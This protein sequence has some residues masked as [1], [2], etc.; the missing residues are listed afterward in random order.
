MNAATQSRNEIVDRYA[1]LVKPIALSLKR[2]LPPCFEADDLVQFGM[3]GLIAAAEK[4]D[5]G[6][7]ETFEQ[8]CRQKIRGAILDGC[9]REFRDSTYDAIEDHV[10]QLRSPE[11]LPDA[12]LE[13]EQTL[14][15][16]AG[17]IGTLTDRQQKVIVMRFN[18]GL[19]QAE[20]GAELGGIS[21]AGARDLENRAV[22]SMRRKLA[23]VIQFPSPARAPEAA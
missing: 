16:L 9:G 22:H 8:Y 20:A 12:L 21:Q 6:R 11:P 15:Q 14:E 4:Y 1:H 10:Y 18:R 3:L 13:K 17:A 2:R 19:T 23:K 5:S 7:A